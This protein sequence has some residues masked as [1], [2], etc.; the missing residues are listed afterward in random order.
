MALRLAAHAAEFRLHAHVHR[1]IGAERVRMLGAPP[2]EDSLPAPISR[3]ARADHR[4]LG[5]VVDIEEQ[6]DLPADPRLPVD[7]VLAP[8]QR[9]DME[10]TAG[11]AG[12]VHAVVEDARTAVQ[13]GVDAIALEPRFPPWIPAAALQPNPAVLPIFVGELP[14]AS[15][16]LLEILAAG[17]VAVA[18]IDL[19]ALHAAAAGAALRPGIGAAASPDAPVVGEHERQIELPAPTIGISERDCLAREH[20]GATIAPKR[21]AAPAPVWSRIAPTITSQSARATP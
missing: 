18:L 20:H 19:D 1:L 6:R 12:M 11:P 9:R 13:A 21:G 4:G 5:L 17:S 2:V 10:C 15:A 8:A 16:D 14:D 7:R 3:P